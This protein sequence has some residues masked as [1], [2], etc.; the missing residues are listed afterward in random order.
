[1]N[2]KLTICKKL[3]VALL[4]LAPLYVAGCDGQAPP[5]PEQAYGHEH[6]EGSAGH[7]TEEASSQEHGEHEGHDEHGGHDEHDQ[8][9]VKLTSA[10]QNEFGIKLEVARK[11]VLAQTLEL[12]GEVALNPANV[13]H[14]IPQV[15]GIVRKVE[16]AIGDEVQA[17]DLLAVLDSRQ[18]ARAK[19]T[20]F[21]ALAKE[22][23]ARANFK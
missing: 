18:L 13:A 23:L 15:P 2:M 7:S 20:Y 16:A 9:I 21:A 19:S 22:Q 10:Q 4:L 11:G 14:V 1:M 5:G 6:A 3:S 12:P 8:S 17:G